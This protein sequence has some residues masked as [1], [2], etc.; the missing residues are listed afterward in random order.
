VPESTNPRACVAVADLCSSAVPSIGEFYAR[1][2]VHLVLGW[3]LPTSALHGL[4]VADAGRND[5][6]GV[7]RATGMTRAE[8]EEAWRNDILAPAPPG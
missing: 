7:A 3:I 6:V 5:I 1:E 2:L 4:V 8:V